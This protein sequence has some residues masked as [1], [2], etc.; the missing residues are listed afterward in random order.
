MKREIKKSGVILIF[1][2]PT[3]GLQFTDI[4]KTESIG[5]GLSFGHTKF[6][7]PIRQISRGGHTYAIMT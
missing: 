4:G 7:M 1:G 3:M 5:L 2:A 6:E